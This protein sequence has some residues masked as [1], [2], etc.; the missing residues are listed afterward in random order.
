[1]YP[2]VEPWTC[3]STY[4]VT[5]IVASPTEKRPRLAL[6]ASPQR[7]VALAWPAIENRGT[8]SNEAAATIR[9]CGRLFLTGEGFEVVPAPNGAVALQLA[10]LVRRQGHGPHR[11][12]HCK[13]G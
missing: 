12:G 9:D 1:M 6:V 11:L 4:G 10:Q 7:P 3:A 13:C 2:A 8:A 5:V